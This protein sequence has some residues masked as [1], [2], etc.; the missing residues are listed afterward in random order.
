MRQANVKLKNKSG[1]NILYEGVKSVS[2]L[3]ENDE[4]KT[5]TLGAPDTLSADLDFSEGN[6][7]IDAPDD[8]LYEKVIIIKPP[9]FTAANI[10][11]DVEIAG[12][13]GA[14]E[15][16][17]EVPQ[18]YTPSISRNG[19]TIYISNNSNNG[20]FCKMFR[21]Y[22]NDK[23]EFSQTSTS[24]SLIGKF[25]AEADYK[26]EASC[27]NEQLVE[28]NKSSSINVSIY[29][30]I[31]EYDE[32]LTT[33]DTTTKISNGITYTF[34]M[35]ANFGYWLPELIEVKEKPNG[36][37]DYVVTDDYTYSMYTGV[38][39]V[40]SMKS[41]LKFLIESLNYAF[42]ERPKGEIDL[43]TYIMTTNL[44]AHA[45]YLNVYLDGVLIKQFERETEDTSSLTKDTYEITNDYVMTLTNT[46]YQNK[47]AP[48]ICH[49]ITIDGEITHN[50]K[51]EWIWR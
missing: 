39:K 19:D 37:E 1:K 22:V 42:L 18:L 33:K 51:E 11:K 36:T 47:K 28:S 5:F 26:I 15:G 32:N 2:L 30:I 13:V 43:D 3:D 35:T 38:I 46:E 6:Q 23:L 40:S 9:N 49:N 14:F 17:K 45:Q 7:E 10:A 29:S 48:Y 21:V 50:L 24:F 12:I 41:N 20:A 4:I 27:Y 16:A 25:A 34:T 31:K 44:T 8:T